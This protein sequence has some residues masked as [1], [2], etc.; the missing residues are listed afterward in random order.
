M[1]SI[2]IRLMGCQ[3]FKDPHVHDAMSE[4]ANAIEKR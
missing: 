1:M 4:D 2:W 3:T